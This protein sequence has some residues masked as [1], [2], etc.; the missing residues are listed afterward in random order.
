MYACMVAIAKQLHIFMLS[1]DPA[2][3][4]NAFQ[5]RQELSPMV[6]AFIDY[7]FCGCS[8]SHHYQHVWDSEQ[9]FKHQTFLPST[10]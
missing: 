5:Q 2:D 6:I 8:S 3:H 9:Y 1:C 10:S 7:T 4:Q